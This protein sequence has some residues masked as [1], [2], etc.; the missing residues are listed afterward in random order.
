MSRKENDWSP[1]QDEQLKKEL[2]GGRCWK[3]Q[4]LPEVRHGRWWWQ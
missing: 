4:R 3:A 1:E 2:L